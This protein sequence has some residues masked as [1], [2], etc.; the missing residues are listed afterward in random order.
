MERRTE[1]E[2]QDWAG[3][4]PDL[5]PDDGDL[6]RSSGAGTSSLKASTSYWTWAALEHDWE[7]GLHWLTAI[8]REV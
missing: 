7:R 1:G 3:G 5:Y 2:K 8:V 6:M 4:G